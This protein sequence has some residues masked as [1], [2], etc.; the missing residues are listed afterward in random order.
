MILG[1]RPTGVVGGRLGGL[2]LDQHVGALVLDRLERPDR[3]AELDP[4]LGVLDRHLEA[5][6]R[7]ADLLEGESDPGP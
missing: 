5:L 4:H 2:D 6:L 1:G 7:P 3:A